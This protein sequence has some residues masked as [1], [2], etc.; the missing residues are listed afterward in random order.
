MRTLARNEDWRTERTLYARGV[1]VATNNAKLHHNYAYYIDDDPALKEH[2]LREAIRLYPPYIS[3]YINLGVVLSEGGRYEEAVETYRRGLD[4]HYK[5]PLYSTDVGVIH[6]NMAAAYLRL[7]QT[8]NALEQ[9]Q[10]C[11][12]VRPGHE[13]CT[14]MVA[15]LSAQLSAQQGGAAPTADFAASVPAFTP[16][17]LAAAQHK[18]ERVLAMFY[19]PWCSHCNEMKPAYAEARRMLAGVAEVGAVDCTVHQ[20]LCHGGGALDIKGYPTVM[21]FR[22]SDAAD[23]RTYTGDRSAQDLVR[24]ARAD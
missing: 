13:Y 7:G 11:L 16:E 1:E 24:F 12:K 10:T 20:A 9:Y 23:A 4:M 18:H 22:G 15:Q 3:A 14:S 2:H 19:A 6:R 21:L 8:A 5:H 17:T